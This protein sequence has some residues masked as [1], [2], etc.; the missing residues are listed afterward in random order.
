MREHIPEDVNREYWE[1]ETID[2]SI[3]GITNYQRVL[4]DYSIVSVDQM[5]EILRYHDSLPESV[6]NKEWN[7]MKWNHYIGGYKVRIHSNSG[8]Y[9]PYH[10]DIL[11][12]RWD[13]KGVNTLISQVQPLLTGDNRPAT[14]YKL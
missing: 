11:L 4:V 13:G 10:I 9:K 7:N 2:A 12:G 8:M 3:M 14:P 5:V 6:R 1:F